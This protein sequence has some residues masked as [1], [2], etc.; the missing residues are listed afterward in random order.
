MIIFGCGCILGGFLSGLLSDLINPQNAGK[1]SIMIV[2][3]VSVITV[4]LKPFMNIF[5]AFICDFL[6][7]IGCKA[8]KLNHIT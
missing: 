1:L 8:K 3:V 5:L 6:W 7:E 2:L 4:L